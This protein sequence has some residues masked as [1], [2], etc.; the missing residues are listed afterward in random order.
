VFIPPVKMRGNHGRLRTDLTRLLTHSCSNR[1]SPRVCVI[2][3][4]CWSQW[5]CLIDDNS[6]YIHIISMVQPHIFYAQLYSLNISMVV[7]FDDFMS[8]Q[9]TLAYI[10]ST[11]F[12]ELRSYHCRFTHYQPKHSV[13]DNH[14]NQNGI[15]HMLL[16]IESY[17]AEIQGVSKRAL[18]RYSKCYCVASVTKTFTLKDIQTIHHSRY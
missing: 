17:Y 14:V 8:E 1:Q 7:V 10:Q 13:T 15:K 2:V 18:E 3:F 11:Q 5:N 6:L 12:L 16:D 4:I 9:C